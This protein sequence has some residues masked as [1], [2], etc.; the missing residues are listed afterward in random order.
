MKEIEK[1][2]FFECDVSDHFTWGLTGTISNVLEAFEPETSSVHLYPFKGGHKDFPFYRFDASTP[3]KLGFHQEFEKSLEG[4]TMESSIDNDDALLLTHGQVFDGFFN[5]YSQALRW[6]YVVWN[7]MIDTNQ[8]L[9]IKFMDDEISL[10][11]RVY[12]RKTSSYNE[13]LVITPEVWEDEELATLLTSTG[14]F[15]QELNPETGKVKLSLSEHGLQKPEYKPGKPNELEDS[16][17]LR[18]MGL[19]KDDLVEPD[20]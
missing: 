10:R 15:R 9:R 3:V 1:Y 12:G 19:K 8:F 14:Y 13:P 5:A 6:D 11:L 16:S 17:Y 20:A 4:F 7:P 18:E 2:S